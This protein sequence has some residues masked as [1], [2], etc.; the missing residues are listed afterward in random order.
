MFTTIDNKVKDALIDRSEI[1]KEK[2]NLDE[3]GDLASKI[4]NS[5]MDLN[6]TDT[7]QQDLLESE[8]KRESYDKNEA[9]QCDIKTHIQSGL[10]LERFQETF[11]TSDEEKLPPY[12]SDNN[13]FSMKESQHE[14][15]YNPE[16]YDEDTTKA[17]K[18]NN[19]QI[20]EGIDGI[21]FSKDDCEL[22]QSGHSE[23]PSVES[24]PTKSKYTCHICNETFPTASSLKK[25][26]LKHPK[27]NSY[28]C[29][30]CDKSF[31]Q[32]SHLRRHH[33]R[34]SLV[35]KHQCEVCSKSFT[36]KAFLKTH[37]LVHTGQKPHEC[38][39]C[40]KK[41]TQ[42]SGLKVHLRIH[43]GERPYQCLVCSKTFKDSSYLKKHLLFHSGERAY[44]CSICSK[45]F[46]QASDLRKHVRIH[47]GDRPYQC[48]QCWKTFA[49]ATNLKSHSYIHMNLNN[50]ASP[51]EFI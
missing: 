19:E 20:E 36:Q 51:D 48:S 30:I 10:L 23:C 13:E 33:K 2:K 45:T 14:V 7:H 18:K 1:K 24:L 6:V 31:T 11:I 21:L 22:E 26:I 38:S 43:S 25:H 27:E 44:K 35:K 32:S 9:F 42:S 4:V 3:I 40:G 28:I 50:E 47:S 15:K 39:I 8:I 37:L 5:E 49:Q 29:P 16:L 17:I 12:A 46:T 34:H 41:F